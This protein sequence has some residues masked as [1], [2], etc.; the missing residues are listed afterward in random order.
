MK[1][2][3]L[4][5]LGLSA[6]QIDSI[7]GMHGADIEGHKGK[8]ATAEETLKSLQDQLSAANKQIED[9]K[10]LKVDEIQKA[11]DDYKA[12]FEQA[13]ADA[14]RQLESLKFDHAL[15]DA[16]K[17]AKVRNP[18]TVTPLL[19]RDA[20]KLKEDGTI[21]GLTDQLTKIR[22]E[23]DYL[24]ADAQPVPKIVTGGHN[25][26]VINDPVISAARKAAGLKTE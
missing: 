17:S 5:K 20:L 14:A 16:L 21:D 12:K 23:N 22:T 11:A 18:Q 25:Q 24:F 26:P 15:S 1:R 10:G 9:F 19:S 13:Q 4:E 6:E 8:V 3:D 7:M 2:G